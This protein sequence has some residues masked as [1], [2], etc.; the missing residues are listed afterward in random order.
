MI[1]VIQGFSGAADKFG[2]HPKWY[3]A[4]QTYSSDTDPPTSPDLERNVV[5]GGLAEYVEPKAEVKPEAP[6]KTTR[7]KKKVVKPDV[8]KPVGPEETK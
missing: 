6:K 7:R 5:A 8:T 1:K 4:G 3:E 2:L